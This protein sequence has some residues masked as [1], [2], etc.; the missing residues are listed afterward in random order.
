VGKSQRFYCQFLAESNVEE[1]KNLPTFGKVMNEL[2]RWPFFD[3][4]CM[5]RS[6][7]RCES[8]FICKMLIAVTEATIDAFMFVTILPFPLL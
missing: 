4:Q 8:S 7:A 1:F 3:S 2:Y 6:W 5:L